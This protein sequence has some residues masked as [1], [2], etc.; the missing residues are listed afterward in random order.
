MGKKY[1]DISTYFVTTKKTGDNMNESVSYHQRL[2]IST[3]STTTKLN[4]IIIK[5]L[6]SIL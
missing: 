4:L 6:Q 3:I 2:I 1:K 5:K